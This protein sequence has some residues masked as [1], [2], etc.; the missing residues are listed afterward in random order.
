MMG[1]RSG[2]SIGPFLLLLS[3]VWLIH[4]VA[5][6]PPSGSSP[7]ASPPATP[8]SGS[9]VAVKPATG[10]PLEIKADHIQYLQNVD[11]YEAEGSV[12]IVQGP[13]RLTADRV[14]LM[15]LT[16]TA[17]AEGHVHMTDPTA[18][19]Q[20]ERLELDVNTEAGVITNGH[21]FI[22]ESDTL[23]TGRLLQRFSE[24]HY[25]AKDGSFT[26]CDAQYGEVPA[27]RFT[28]KDMDLN[29]GEG[30]YA[31]SAWMCVNDHPLVPF[32]TMF[33]P[34]QTYRKT[35][36][37][38]PTVGYDNRFGFH[39]RQSFFWAFNPSQD[40]IITPDFL[41]N[42]GYGGDVEYRYAIDARSRGQW[43]MSFIDD[44]KVHK[45]RALFSGLHYQEVNPSLRIAGQAFIVTDPNYL[46]DLSNSGVQRALPSGDSNLMLT[47]R[48]PYGN[49]YLL[50][51]YFQP[52]VSGG[53]DTFQ[54]LPELGYQV[55]NYAPLDG[56]VLLGFDT[57]IS[58]FYREQGFKQ[59]RLDVV[60]SIGTL[61]LN[62]GRVVNF[63][64]QVKFREVYYTHNLTDT[65]PVHRETFWA[66]MQGGSRLV[67][68][69]RFEDGG[70]VL[71]TIE[72]NVVYEYV[73]QTPQSQIVQID[74]VDDL[75]KKNL[76]TYSL[77]SRVMRQSSSGTTSWLDMLIAQ[78]YHPGSTPSRAIDFSVPPQFGTL[79]QPLQLPAV[80]VHTNK[81]SD[82]W[83]RSVIGNPV[84]P[85][86]QIDH[87]LT[88]DAFYDPYR[89]MFSQ[90]NTD[91]RFQQGAELVPRSGTA[92]HARGVTPPA[93]RHL[94][95]DLV[96]R[97]LCADTGIDLRHGIGG[98]SRSLGHGVRRADLLRHQERQES[99]NGSGRTLS[100]PVPMLVGR[101]LLHPVSRSG[102]I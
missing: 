15:M 101:I 61:P 69:Y 38:I 16:G 17:I 13:I 84:G 40:V 64:P 76:V 42:R 10:A 30:V 50:G 7:S 34:I 29:I 1:R 2:L 79:T 54:R 80:P 23:I 89:N 87:V 56:P 25:R 73:P 58:N 51:Q 11:V 67:R 31:R 70:S 63:T 99:G 8:P 75:I 78:S 49:L 88:I 48:V 52:L 74:N 68:R 71:H 27:W 92:P 20:G 6:A 59:D 44:I 97:G 21:I 102:P 43:L 4:P 91:L 24:N 60:P 83:L 9:A 94:E 22:K 95:P 36:F 100:Q 12:V 14:T 53:K 37:L 19:I 39:Y 57:A 77:T 55:Y 62:I 26:N 18:D 28:F 96:Q 72:P 66:S 86:R 45:P 35:G 46:S 47:Q 5:A 81:F 32:P 82:I 3:I 90:F 98:V 85:I 41:S 33:Y 65:G 93:G